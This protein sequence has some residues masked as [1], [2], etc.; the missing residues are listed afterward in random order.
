MKIDKNFKCFVVEL[1]IEYIRI[2][3]YSMNY[4]MYSENC[5]CIKYDNQIKFLVIPLK[6]DK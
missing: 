2:K 3:R 6:L 5:F 1:K 4:V